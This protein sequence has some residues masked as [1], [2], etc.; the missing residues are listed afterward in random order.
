MTY[1][2]YTDRIKKT[3]QAS[4]QSLE[5]MID[6]YGIDCVIRSVADIAGAKAE[7]IATAW[8]DASLAKRWAAVG[9]ALE[10]CV[11]GASGL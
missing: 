5:A 10:R 2:D 1:T 9:A 8:Q 4:M 6:K 11:Y 3:D 7:H